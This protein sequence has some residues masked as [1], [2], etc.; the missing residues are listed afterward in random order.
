M[1]KQ[2]G[3]RTTEDSGMTTLP[4]LKSHDPTQSIGRA[5]WTSEGLECLFPASSEITHGMLYGVFGH[6]LKILE[7]VDGKQIVLRCRVYGMGTTEWS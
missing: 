6:S 7:Y 1:L 2:P 3:G 5:E 4:L